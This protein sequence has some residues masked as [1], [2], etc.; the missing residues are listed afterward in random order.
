MTI[1]SSRRRFLKQGGTALGTGWL[2]ANWPAALEAADLA[3]EAH[4]RGLAFTVLEAR[5]AVDLEAIAA[6]ILPTTETPG[7]RELGVI[8]FIDQ[9]MGSFMAGIENVLRPGLLELNANAAARY[10]AERFHRLDGEAQDALLAEI[11]SGAF[12]QTL[13][14]MTL[15]GAFASPAHG[16]N[17]N[18][19]GWALL[20][21]QDRHLWFPPFGHYDAAHHTA[22]PGSP[23]QRHGDHGEAHHDE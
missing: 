18:Q 10:G 1:D 21:F 9:A 13:R 14:T 11:D 12:F 15:M 17:R 20:G 23:A 7:A 8:H 19:A 6:R 3:A 2:A 22:G 4:A 5:E 16:G